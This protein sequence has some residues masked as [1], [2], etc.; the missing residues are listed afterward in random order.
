MALFLNGKPAN[1]NPAIVEPT[2]IQTLWSGSSGVGV[3]SLNR[4]YTDYDLITFKAYNTAY[5]GWL[6][7]SFSVDSLSLNATILACLGSTDAQNRR[8]IGKFTSVREFT[9]QTAEN[10]TTLVEIIGYKFGTG[11]A[12]QPVIYSDEEREIGV[13]RDGKPLYEKTFD[14]GSDTYIS[15]NSWT[16][17]SISW[18]TLDVDRLVGA[19]GSTSSGGTFA[20]T[21][22]ASKKSNGNI[23]IQTP[24][25]STNTGVRYLT[26]R[27]TKT[28]DTAGSEAWTPQ[29][30]PSHHYSINEKVVGQWIDRKPIYEKTVNIAQY[31]VTATDTA[32]T[33]LF[34][35]SDV[36]YLVGAESHGNSPNI[37]QILRF[38]ANNGYIQI[39]SKTNINVS[40]LGTF[41]FTFRYT[42]STD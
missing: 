34:A 39:A 6:S 25:N 18:Q 17:T 41:Y 23:E 4:N 20:G 33:N 35:I 7:N 30:I 15:Y 1:N 32:W 5:Q 22:L 14:L 42:K 9:I 3:V 21:L 31:S 13:W 29:G 11:Y 10:G 16:E 19:E 40:V 2:E 28:T 27:Y 38:Q 37:G 12:V 26:L 8:I 36:N 24:R